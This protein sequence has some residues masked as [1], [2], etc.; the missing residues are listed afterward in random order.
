MIREL[1]ASLAI[2]P[3]ITDLLMTKSSRA[4]EVFHR[5]WWQKDPGSPDGRCPGVGRAIRIGWA[6]T[7]TEA[8][9][10]CRQWNLTHAPGHLSDKAEY[11]AA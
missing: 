1:S 5:T 6:A 7:E 11:W 3:P 2:N 9:E 10:M 4:F 8:R